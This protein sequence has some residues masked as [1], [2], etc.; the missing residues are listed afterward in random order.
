M[1]TQGG[2]KERAGLHRLAMPSAK[3]LQA[4]RAPSLSEHGL[5]YDPGGIAEVQTMEG[6]Q[7]D[8]ERYMYG[9]RRTFDRNLGFFGK[10]RKVLPQLRGSMGI[11]YP[12][13]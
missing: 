12:H 8:K 11:K 6:S 10:S 9:P 3:S 4:L 7:A 5:T 13:P 2:W 1:D